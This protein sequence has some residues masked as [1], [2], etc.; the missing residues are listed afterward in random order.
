MVGAGVPE[1]DAAGVEGDLE[2]DPSV[3]AGA[4]GEDGAVVAEHA[5]RIAVAGGGFAE[6]VID[7]AGLEH[8][9]GV[10]AEAEPGVVVELVE[11]LHLGA[12]GQDP[13]G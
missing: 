3:P 7:V 4:A 11:D 10:A 1:P 13:S 8:G 6:A 2:Y 12:V 9:H 5:G